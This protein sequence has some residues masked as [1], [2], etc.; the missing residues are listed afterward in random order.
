M[1]RYGAHEISANYLDRVVMKGRKAMGMTIEEE[2][3][4]RLE[5]W[6][7]SYL[8]AQLADPA[9]QAAQRLRHMK[10]TEKGTSS[11]YKQAGEAS[12]KIIHQG[13][14]LPQKTMAAKLV[15]EK[16]RSIKKTSRPPTI[17]DVL[18]AKRENSLRNLMNG[19]E[20]ETL[21]TLQG[22]PQKPI[23]KESKPKRRASMAGPA[24]K[25]PK[26]KNQSP[27]EQLVM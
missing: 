14:R 16:I 27:S 20:E 22:I 6:C 26:G 15:E 11:G 8:Q 21:P 5:T 10:T 23:R 24:Q 4:E 25:Q 9:F 13:S 7:H 18:E 2:W 19:I 3:T 12:H 1:R 17:D